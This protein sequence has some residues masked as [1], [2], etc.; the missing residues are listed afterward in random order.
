MTLDCAYIYLYIGPLASVGNLTATQLNNTSVQLSWTPPYT[1]DNVPITGYYIDIFNTTV[2][3]TNT[4]ITLTNTDPCTLTNVSVYP[5]NGAGMGESATVS[6]Y[7][8]RGKNKLSA[9]EYI[10][11][12]S[13]ASCSSDY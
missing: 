9:L 10:L 4:T 12:R 7:S 8:L 6:F 1:L 13:K 2:T 3:D 11:S 5:V